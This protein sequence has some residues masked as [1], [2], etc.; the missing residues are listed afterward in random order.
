MM[1]Y[2]DLIINAMSVM[3]YPH[4]LA[5]LQDTYRFIMV[6]EFQDTDQYQWTLIQRLCDSFSPFKTDKLFLVG[7]VKQSIYSFRHADPE[8]FMS[9]FNTFKSSP[10]LGK[11][12]HMA[13]NF[14]SNSVILNFVNTLFSSLFETSTLSIPYTPLTAFHNND[15]SISLGLLEPYTSFK[16]EADF[17]ARWIL[18]LVQTTDIVPADI[19]ILTR[20]KTIF[21]VLKE[22]LAQVNIPVS[23]D[24]QINFFRRDHSLDIIHIVELFIS[25]YSPLALF[26]LLKSPLIG[27]SEEKL[28]LL[29]HNY[30]TTYPE[31]TPSLF[32]QFKTYN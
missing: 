5:Q 3:E 8:I 21:P 14:R 27:L 30:K 7:D 16:E 18:K 4:C 9:V 29:Q 26:A 12:I 17:I 28:F 11:V 6:D 15:S 19:A 13:D 20:R 32:E 31:K 25:P 1:D 22:A 2:D 10:Q 23:V 24:I